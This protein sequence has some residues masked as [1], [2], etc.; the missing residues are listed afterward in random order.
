MAL[1][2]V[3]LTP[4]PREKV[5]GSAHLAPWF[6]DSN[7]NIGEIWFL[8]D[9][10]LPVLIKFLFTSGKLSIQVHPDDAYAREHENSR[11]KTE[12][13]HVL[14]A[15]PGAALAAGFREPLERSQLLEA[16]TSGAIERLI[17][18]RE[19]SAGETLF[20]P[21]GTVHAIGAGLV[22]CEVQ[23]NS[24][25]T[26]RLY[27]YGRPREL[28]LDKAIAVAD[29]RPHPGPTEM[30]VKSDYFVTASLPLD[31]PMIVPAQPGQT[32]FF[33]VLEGGGWIGEQ[34]FRLGE[35]WML[36]PAAGELTLEGSARLLHV[37]CPEE[38]AG[39]YCPGCRRGVSD[40]LVCGD[41][42]SVICRV[43]GAALERVDDLG[44]G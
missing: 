31:G 7:K 37:S 35:V 39:L 27:D 43:C 38:T 1:A 18:W 29:L 11:G 41:C 36:P 40:P 34:P 10:E 32:Q 8:A 28:H 2:A 4:S 42:T 26:Y 14:R 23:Q 15:E 22:L 24:D 3:R 44:I 20:I 12:M 13:W 30:P 33:V 17:A 9:R 16:A 25:I 6:P 5:W 19:A 21:A